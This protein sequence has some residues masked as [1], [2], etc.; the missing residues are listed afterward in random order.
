[1]PG[2]QAQNVI[3]VAEE[4]HDLPPASTLADGLGEAAA[5]PPLVLLLVPL[6]PQAASTAAAVSPARPTV[7]R[8]AARV[9]LRGCLVGDGT[10]GSRTDLDIGNIAG[11]SP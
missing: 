5:L 7:S 10:L 2:T 8:A 1:M 6:L 3:F 9:D 11:W 4:P